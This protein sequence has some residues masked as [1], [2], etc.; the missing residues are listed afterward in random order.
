[1]ENPKERRRGKLKGKV[2]I[3]CRANELAVCTS[4]SE[5]IG[6]VK[7]VAV[8]ERKHKVVFRKAGKQPVVSKPSI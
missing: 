3:N 4:P 7:A 5:L 1:M 8:D 2:T 6:I